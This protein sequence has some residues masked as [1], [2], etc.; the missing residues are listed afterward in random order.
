M[1]GMGIFSGRTSEKF[2]LTVLL[3]LLSSSVGFVVQSFTFG[4]TRGFACGFIHS[5]IAG[6]SHRTP[7]ESLREPSKDVKLFP[8]APKGQ[9]GGYR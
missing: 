4:F 7:Q 3:F 6:P 9:G 8:E 5:F 2:S 1:F